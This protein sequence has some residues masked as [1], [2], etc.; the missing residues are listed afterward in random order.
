MFFNTK[1]ILLVKPVYWGAKLLCRVMVYLDSIGLQ[2][3]KGLHAGQENWKK[4]CIIC[5][6]CR[7]LSAS[8]RMPGF[9]H[10]SKKMSCRLKSSIALQLDTLNY[11]KT[12]ERKHCCWASESGQRDGNL[13]QEVVRICVPH[14]IWIVAVAFLRLFNIILDT[15]TTENSCIIII[16]RGILDRNL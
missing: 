16:A 7:L 10:R 2:K 6:M 8:Y 5:P 9:L 4:D 11:N 3:S 15:F 14:T 1:S 13:I 12:L